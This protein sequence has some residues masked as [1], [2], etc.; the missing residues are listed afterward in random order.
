MSNIDTIVYHQVLCNCDAFADVAQ[1]WQDLIVEG[2]TTDGSY[3][4]NSLNPAMVAYAHDNTGFPAGVLVY[5]ERQDSSDNFYYWV[6]F[7]HVREDQRGKG[8]AKEM[9]SSFEE[10]AKREGAHYISF[11]TH[12]ANID[13]QRTAESVNY[14][15]DAIIYRKNL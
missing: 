3:T 5:S 11:G 6:D 13:M 2:K 1:W 4:L 9:L 7:L 15:A 10:F 8:L 12:R 14:K